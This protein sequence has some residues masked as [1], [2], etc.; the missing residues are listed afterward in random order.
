MVAKY[1]QAF[2]HDAGRRVELSSAYAFLFGKQRE[3]IFIGVT[4]DVFAICLPANVRASEC[5]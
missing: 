5:W 1:K 3:G 2:L 4:T